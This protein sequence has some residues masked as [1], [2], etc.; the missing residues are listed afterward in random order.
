LN[1]QTKQR[2]PGQT[3]GRQRKI[4]ALINSVYYFI[5]YVYIVRINGLYRLVADHDGKRLMDKDYRTLRGAKIAF[6]KFFKH[7]N[8]EKNVKAEW[9][10][11]YEPEFQWLKE[12]EGR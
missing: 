1:D 2:F 9:S 5:D 10:R 4:C 8:W 3:P 11:F 7:R 6:S 12:K